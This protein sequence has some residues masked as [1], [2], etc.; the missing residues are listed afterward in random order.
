MTELLRA[1]IRACDEYDDSFYDAIVELTQELKD[2]IKAAFVFIINSK[3]EVNSV[4]LSVD[5]LVYTVLDDTWRDME[6][7]CS[8]PFYEII[9][10]TKPITFDCKRSDC[11][12]IQVFNGEFAL[13]WYEKHGGT[14]E[15]DLLPLEILEEECQMN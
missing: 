8:V 15:S 14:W 3:T 13:Q 5:Y 11:S 2:R 1:R 7:D 10:E 9:S 4:N 6:D 12:F